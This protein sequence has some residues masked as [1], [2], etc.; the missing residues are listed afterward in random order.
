[1]YSTCIIYHNIIPLQY[2]SILLTW[3]DFH[4]IL[5]KIFSESIYIFMCVYTFI[6]ALNKV[7]RYV[8]KVLTMV[9]T[10]KV[11]FGV[12]LIFLSAFS[13]LFSTMNM[14]YLPNI[15]NNWQERGIF[16]SERGFI[17][18]FFPQRRAQVKF[19]FTESLPML[20]GEKKLPQISKSYFWILFASVALWCQAFLLAHSLS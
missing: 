13:H 8:P 1:M 14:Y 11:G 3:N 4:S 16:Q 9:E 15:K 7:W 17:Q 10:G 12:I 18:A 19:M 2:S 20:E 5:I 6:F